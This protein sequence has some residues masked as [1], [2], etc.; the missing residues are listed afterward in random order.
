[1]W[2]FFA[3]SS[4]C[5][6]I[7]AFI[8][9]VIFC[10]TLKVCFIFISYISFVFCFPLIVFASVSLSSFLISPLCIYKGIFIYSG[11]NQFIHFTVS[12]WLCT[13]VVPCCIPE[14]NWCVAKVFFSSNLQCSHVSRVGSR[15]D[16]INAINE[17]LWNS[18]GTAPI[19]TPPKGL[20]AVAFVHTWVQSLCSRLHKLTTPRGGKTEFDLNGLNTQCNL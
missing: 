9:L 4:P 10:F 7:Y 8:T 20:G 1:M 13:S 17:P 3:P 14:Y 11:P 6:T 15:S 16:H 18:F 2:V 5:V 19:P 12:Y